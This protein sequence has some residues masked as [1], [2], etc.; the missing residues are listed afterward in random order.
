MFTPETRALRVR[1]DG[2]GPPG[3]DALQIIIVIA[4]MPLVAQVTCSQGDPQAEK[5]KKLYSS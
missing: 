2:D 3:A 5:K 1:S 4:V